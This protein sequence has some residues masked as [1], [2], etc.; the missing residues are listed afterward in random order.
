MT[1]LRKWLVLGGGGIVAIVMVAAGVL[2]A[3]SVYKVERRWEFSAR[4]VPV[5]AD[6]ATVAHGARLVRIYGCTGC[7]GDDLGGTVFAD[8]PMFGRLVAP[9][10]TRVRTVY[11]DGDF[12]RLLRHGVRPT[13]KS[14][15]MAMPSQAFT[16]LADDDLGALIAYIRSLPAV[17]DSLPGTRFALPLRGMLTLG[18]VDMAPSL[19]DH[20]ASPRPTI[21]RADLPRWGAY[22][23]RSACSECHGSDLRGQK[24]FPTTPSLAIVAAY[25]RE[26]F[27]TFF[28]TGVAL[29]GR[30]LEL[31]SRMTRTRFSAFTDREIDALHAYLSTMGTGPD[32]AS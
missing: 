28:R 18:V 5:P 12:V 7:H 23:A 6:S 22:L 17:D 31:M 25:S 32:P 30:E 2:Y 4:T 15:I 29:G 24:R 20:T 10:L 1:G 13:G 16:D 14:V 21:D 11:S 8:E 27:R 26:E 9:N 3:V 19:I